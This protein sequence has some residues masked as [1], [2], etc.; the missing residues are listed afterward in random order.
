[1]NIETPEGSTAEEY[2]QING[3]TCNGTPNQASF[4]MNRTPQ[5]DTFNFAT[6]EDGT[7]TI[8]GWLQPL[9]SMNIPSSINGYNVSTIGAYA[10]ANSS[11][12]TDITI[13]DGIKTIEAGAFE[14]IGCEISSGSALT[15]KILGED[16]TIA[17]NAFSSIYQ[18]LVFYV[19]DTVKSFLE[20]IKQANWDIFNID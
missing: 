3:I 5:S 13:A 10:F 11:T 7:L 12:V 6:N 4:S 15:I 18:R 17:E 1:M 20:S 8:T 16:V 2:A 14:N 19:T 9:T